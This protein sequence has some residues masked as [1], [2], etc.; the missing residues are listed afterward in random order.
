MNKK[1][2]LCKIDNC[3]NILIFIR[4]QIN[5][6]IS[7]IYYY[8]IYYF[9]ILKLVFNIIYIKYLKIFTK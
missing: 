8:I 3:K 9:Y 6:N 1:I 2:S 4:I 7:I 5:L